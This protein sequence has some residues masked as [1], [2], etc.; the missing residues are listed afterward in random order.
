M[1]T[2]AIKATIQHWNPE[3]SNIIRHY[4][5]SRYG[6]YETINPKEKWL[7]GTRLARGAPKSEN[8]ECIELSYSNHPLLHH[9]PETIYVYLHRKKNGLDW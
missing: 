6:K 3:N 1:G 8:Y 5:T 4:I 2:I 9:P 7:P